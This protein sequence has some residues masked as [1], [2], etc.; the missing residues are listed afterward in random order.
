MYKR[1]IPHGQVPTTDPLGLAYDGTNLYVL[2]DADPFDKVVVVNPATGAI[3]RSFDTDSSKAQAI[4]HVSGFIYVGFGN[5]RNVQKYQKTSGMAVGSRIGASHNDS[6]Q[7]QDING[8]TYNGAKFVWPPG[9]CCNGDSFQ[10]MSLTGSSL[11]GWDFNSGGV[12]TEETYNAITY[13]AST[14]RYYVG[15]DLSLIHI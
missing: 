6:W 3:V 12:A 8:L 9:S 10:T 15:K 1:Q 14:E 4:T 7:Y 5:E 11:T 13:R 2:V